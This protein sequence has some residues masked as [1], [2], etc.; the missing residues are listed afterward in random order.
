MG[1]KGR[2]TISSNMQMCTYTAS[3]LCFGKFKFSNRETPNTQALTSLVRAD[4]SR[5]SEF[6]YVATIKQ[7]LF[8]WDKKFTMLVEVVT[9]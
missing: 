4:N 2:I 7:E 6:R 8:S 1:A 3:L 9:L 5:F